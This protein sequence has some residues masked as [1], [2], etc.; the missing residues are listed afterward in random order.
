[1]IAKKF[2]KVCVDGV[3]IYTDRPAISVSAGTSIQADGYTIVKG[4][5]G[6]EVGIT[7]YADPTAPLFKARAWFTGTVLPNVPFFNKY[8]TGGGEVS[9]EF[10]H[11]KTWAPDKPGEGMGTSR[12]NF[13]PFSDNSYGGNN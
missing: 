8:A 9:G 7:P 1:M 12:I 11:P 2:S 6:C 10:G 3:C 4:E 5:V 13:D